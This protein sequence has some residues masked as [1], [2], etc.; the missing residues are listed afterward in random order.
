[1]TDSHLRRLPDEVPALPRESSSGIFAY[2]D[3]KN[4][5]MFALLTALLTGAC[6]MFAI[7]NVQSYVQSRKNPVSTFSVVPM[8]PLPAYS[9]LISA[10]VYDASSATVF[11]AR[12]QADYVNG[13]SAPFLPVGR[14]VRLPTFIGTQKMQFY[15][16]D[17][18]ALSS[19]DP[20]VMVTLA[21][22]MTLSEAFVF[23]TPVTTTDAQLA[24]AASMSALNTLS[25]FKLS[26]LTGTSILVSLSATETDARLIGGALTQ[27][28][29]AR[30]VQTYA[31]TGANAVAN[32]FA[33][34]SQFY[35]A[36]RMS[37][38][39]NVFSSERVAYQYS[40]EFADLMTAIFTIVN[41]CIGALFLFFP[42]VHR[43]LALERY[44][45]LAPC[46]LDDK[47]GDLGV[48]AELAATRMQSM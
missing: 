25:G 42:R 47:S 21:W 11:S 12:L 44:R 43:S 40:F 7:A 26:V 20:V 37:P 15:R 22:N 1:M 34:S 17:L 27:Y 19:T 14:L 3:S 6:I 33:G 23:I 16:V 30:V 29:T 18:P 9:I 48:P 31:A 2:L 45:V 36:V 5:V 39:F 35:G 28:T 38:R 32:P 41:I 13:G 24:N 10:G 8:D 46:W 4:R